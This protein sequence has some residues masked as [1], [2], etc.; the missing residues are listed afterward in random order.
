MGLLEVS[1]IKT[2]LLEEYTGLID[3]GELGK[4]GHEQTEKNFLSKALAAHSVRVL[5]PHAEK[6]LIV[7]YI[8]DGSEDNG[9]DL[10]YYNKET[11][12]LC[13]VQSKFNAKGDSEPELGEIQSFVTGIRDLINLKFD[14]FNDKVNILKDEIIEILKKSRLKFKIVLAYTAIN[15]SSHSKRELND[16]IDELN[17][18][19]NVAE[20]EIVSQK[21]L[22]ASLSSL[23]DSRNIDVEVQLKEWGRYEGDMEAFYGQ[24]SASQLA[25]WWESYGNLLFDFN[26]RKVLGTTEINDE[27]RSTLE[28]EPIYFWYYNNGITLVCEDVDKKRMFGNSREFGIFECKGISIV[29]GAQTVGVL[30]KFGQVSA[31]SFERLKEVYVPFRI[32][33]IKRVDED[34]K[35][36]L[37]EAFAAAVTTTNNRQNNIENRDFLV[38][39]PVQKKFE[40]DLRL[41]GITYHLMRSEN[42]DVNDENNFGLKEATRALSFAFDI[43]AAILVSREIGLVWSDINHSRYKKLFNPSITGYYIWNCVRIQRWI[44][45]VI[46]EIGKEVDDEEKSILIYGKALISKIIFDII[47]TKNIDKNSLELSSKIKEIDLK[48]KITLILTQISTKILDTGKNTASIFRTPTDIK[49][50]YNQIG[51][52]LSSN[53]DLDKASEF[54]ISQITGFSRTERLQLSNFMKKFQSDELAVEFFRIWLNEMFD[55]DSYSFGYQSNI[56]FYTNDSSLAATD[57][58]LFRIAYYTKL[59]VS[60]E[61][62]S[63]GALYKSVFY[64][65]PQFKKWAEEN[66]DEKN[67]IV[68]NDKLDI[69]KLVQLK[70]FLV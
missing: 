18:F 58:F 53:E 8:V 65:D 21:R 49:K 15:L 51:E 31:E 33:S 34:D 64:K 23:N 29:N 36:Y 27:I 20:L 70:S 10:I 39:D 19:R 67:R 28:T 47:E 30:G 9:L 37:D 66:L 14:K 45:L 17:D 56:H 48:S 62:R 25:E 61:F 13:L 3:V 59:I 43:D 55:K 52:D 26:L 11:N 50:L 24:I 69:E 16:L 63:Y 42:D 12:E 54:D 40:N 57:K 2:K 60:F 6:E 1:Q 5:Y 7:K 44:E 32:I 38:L 46:E 35:E 22:H 41:A 4:H 68:L